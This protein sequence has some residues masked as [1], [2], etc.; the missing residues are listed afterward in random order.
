[1]LVSGWYISGPLNQKLIPLPSNHR[2][3]QDRFEFWR[4]DSRVGFFWWWGWSASSADPESL[5]ILDI[6]IGDYVIHAVLKG[7]SLD[8]TVGKLERTW[9][10]MQKRPPSGKVYER[11]WPNGI[12]FHQPRL[13][14]NKGI[15]LTK[16]PFGV[17]TF[18]ILYSCCG[19][20]IAAVAQSEHERNTVSLGKEYPYRTRIGLLCQP[21]LQGGPQTT[22]YKV[23]GHGAPYK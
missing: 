1:M 19:R 16:A 10:L 3:R 21:N 8:L 9:K 11:L 17:R 13:P 20:H 14:W 6:C 15:S 18:I 12:I 4:G 7:D 22:G 5:G 2:W 23:E